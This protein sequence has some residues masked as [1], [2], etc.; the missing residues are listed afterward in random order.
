MLKP[1]FLMSPIAITDQKN[2]P[3]ALVWSTPNN[4]SKVE[5][6]ID[7][8]HKAKAEMVLIEAGNKGE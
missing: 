1:P 3:Q 5:P 6:S 2:G 4:R 7:F 8:E